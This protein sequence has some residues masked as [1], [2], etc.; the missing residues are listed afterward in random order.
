MHR[1]GYGAERAAEG[2]LIEH[3]SGLGVNDAARA[4]RLVRGI[5]GK[6]LLYKDS[7]VP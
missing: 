3:F 2:L 6:R 7:C 4:D 1:V 5:V